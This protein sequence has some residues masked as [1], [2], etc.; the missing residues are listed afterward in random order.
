MTFVNHILYDHLAN[1][2]KTLHN[3]F[4]EE[5]NLNLF[6]LSFSKGK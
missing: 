2:K 3:E 5:M 1:F 6:K 4:S